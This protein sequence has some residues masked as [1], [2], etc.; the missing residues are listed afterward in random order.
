MRIITQLLN[1]LGDAFTVPLLLAAGLLILIGLLRSVW[2]GRYLVRRGRRPLVIHVEYG[3]AGL[4]GG[5]DYG[6]LDARLLSYLAFD[7]LGSYVIAPGADGGAAPSVP[8]ESPESFSDLLRFLRFAFPAEPAYRVEVTWPGPARH[9]DKLQATVRIS[10]TPG[11]RIVASRSFSEESTQALVEVIGSY[12]VVFL[13]SQPS[14]V[15]STPRWERWNQD[16]TGYLHYRRG[17]DIE[18]RDGEPTSLTAYREALKHFDHAARIDPANMLVQLHRGTLLE[19]LGDHDGAVTLYRKCSTLWPEHIEVLYR[20][21]TSYKEVAIGAFLPEIVAPLLMV[22]QQ[23]SYR[24]LWH[25]WLGTWHPGHWNPGERAYWRSWISLRPWDRAS[26]RTAYLRAV[27]V[28]ELVL[29]LSYLIPERNGGALAAGP[30]FPSGPQGQQQVGSLLAGLA[31]VLLRPARLP[32]AERLLRPDLEGAFSTDYARIPSYAGTHYRRRATGWLAT[33]NAACFFSLAIWLPVQYVPDGFTPEEWRRCCARASVH[34]LGR[35]HRDPRNALDPDWIAT[36]PDLE[37]LR[38]TDVGLE[39]MAFIGLKP[40]RAEV[41][42]PARPRHWPA[43]AAVV[44][45]W[46]WR[47]ASPGSG[48]KTLQVPPPH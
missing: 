18:R 34:E 16:Y 31:A 13:L 25:A 26:K 32:T 37:P 9:R 40:A 36:D 43:G 6:V 28:A 48:G 44:R 27:A 15:R 47:A 5:E 19:L 45:V 24:H 23:L 20:L 8:A 12:C 38:R 17:L 33:F 3:K 11:N 14:I 10:E 2:T 42:P 41:P 21:L 39:W 4:E 30:G 1:S 7:D 46:P 29:A 35:I 22:R